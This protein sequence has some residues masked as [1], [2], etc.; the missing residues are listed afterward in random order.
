MIFCAVSPEHIV[1][2]FERFIKLT[3]MT[4]RL[5]TLLGKIEVN[6]A[7]KYGTR[8]IKPKVENCPSQI[9][10]IN[11]RKIPPIISVIFFCYRF[12]SIIWRYTSVQDHAQPTAAQAMSKGRQDSGVS[13][14]F[15]DQ[16]WQKTCKQTWKTILRFD[17]TISDSQLKLCLLVKITKLQ[18]NLTTKND[19]E[20]GFPSRPSSLVSVST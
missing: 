17:G 11:F 6:H 12:P 5:S 10:S 3:F 2:K 18:R 15:Y 20:I 8:A 7:S 1:V 4:K 13:E 14:A 16:K 9:I 19:S